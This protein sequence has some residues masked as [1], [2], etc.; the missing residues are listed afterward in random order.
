MVIVGYLLDKLVSGVRF[1]TTQWKY[2]K[3]PRK[4]IVKLYLGIG[5]VVNA[6]IF[7]GSITT[8]SAD[9]IEPTCFTLF[10]QN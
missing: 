8:S 4:K 9:T 3:K 7:L 6:S 1:F 2:L 10:L 5:Q